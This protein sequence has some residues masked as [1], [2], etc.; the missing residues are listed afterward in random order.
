M[1]SLWKELP[2]EQVLK[3]VVF[4]GYFAWNRAVNQVSFTI[5]GLLN[6]SYKLGLLIILHKS[7]LCT[8]W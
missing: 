3:I 6:E 7:P 8:K 1:S 4:L 5:Y 2:K